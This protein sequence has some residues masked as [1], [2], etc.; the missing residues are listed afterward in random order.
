MDS[1]RTNIGRLLIACAWVLVAGCASRSAAPSPKPSV[2]ATGKSFA[3]PK[4][5]VDALLAACRSGDEAALLAIFGEEAKPLL[6]TGNAAA[7]RERCQRL[8]AAAAKMTRLDP[9]GPDTVELVVGPDDWP[10]PIPLVKD[11][12]SWRFDTARGAREIIARQVGADEI[13]AIAVCRAYVRA[14]ETYRTRPGGPK[15]YAQR[16]LS[17]PGKKDGLYWPT[18]GTGDASPFGPVVAAAGDDG[19]NGGSWWGYYFRVLTAQGSAAPGGAGSYLVGGRMT[20]GFAMVAYPVAYGTSGIMT[21]IVGSDGRV[22][23][24]DLGEKTDALVGAM[25]AYNPDASWKLVTGTAGP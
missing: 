22:Y 6:S 1:F 8:D 18:T 25:T 3:N 23:E 15:V 2:A 7:D 16:L 5:A 19:K 4:A 17:S 13:E 12:R 24:K 10:F 14:Q 11:G 21:F 9:K 20:L